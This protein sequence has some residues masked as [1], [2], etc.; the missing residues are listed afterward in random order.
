[1]KMKQLLLTV[2]C[3]LLHLPLFAT[4]FVYEGISYNIL[5]DVD[6]TVEIAPCNNVEGDIVIPS[7]VTFNE[8][9]YSVIALGNDAFGICQTM[10]SIVLPNTIT[11]IGH[12]AFMKCTSLTS[13]NF[14]SSL[15]SIGNGV[16]VSCPLYASVILPDGLESLGQEAF[17]EC[18]NLKTI[19]IPKSVTSIGKWC[20]L[21]SMSLTDIEVDEDNPAY[22]SENGILYNKDKTELIMCPRGKDGEAKVFKETENIEASAFSACAKLEH[23]YSYSPEPPACESNAFMNINPECIL[24]IPI[25]SKAVYKTAPEWKTIT[26]VSEDLTNSLSDSSVKQLSIYPNPAFEGFYITDIEVESALVQ[27]VDL[28]GKVVLEQTVSNNQ[29]VDI[30]CLSQGVYMLL[31]Q[32]GSNKIEQKI[33]KL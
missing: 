24:H 12:A 32:S 31:C 21:F 3:V 20:F 8:V 28:N 27:I 10:T 16:F 5:S 23:L 33:I 14:P 19:Q 9:D 25:G 18:F 4:K 13:I 2:V 22:S 17:G 26:K 29:Y 11:S 7:V 1:M 30:S 15:K 6:K